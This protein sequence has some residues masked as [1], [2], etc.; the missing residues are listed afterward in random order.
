[1]P[2]GGTTL[3]VHDA[4]ANLVEI[5][6][7]N[8]RSRRLQYDESGRVVA[9][10]N[11]EGH[12]SRYSY[13]AAGALRGVLLSNGAQASFDVDPDGHVCR[14]VNP[15]GGV[16]EL[17]WA[18]YNVVHEIRRPAG[19]VV[20]FRYDR[21]CN[22][23]RIINENGEEHV[24]RR[25]AAGRIAGETHF[26][27]RAYR[28]QLDPAG[29]LARLENGAGEVTEIDRDAAGRVKKRTYEDGHDKFEYDADGRLI[30]GET[31]ATSCEFAY[32]VRGNLVRESQ[33]TAGR[34]FV[35][36]S[37][38]DA[39]GSRVAVRT[40]AGEVRFER[41][42]MCALR[43][44]HLPGGATIERT[45]DGLGR[46]ILRSLPGGGQIWQK[47]SPVGALVER[48][49]AGP[50]QAASPVSWVGALPAN[51]VFAESYVH[52]AGGELLEHAD[53]TGARTVFEH[54]PGGRVLARKASRGD[55]E[56]YAHD[57][58][59]R[60]RE[61]GLH[62]PART[63]GAGGALLARGDVEYTYDAEARRIARADRGTGRADRYVW[64]SRGLLAAVVLEGGTRVENVHDSSARRLLKRVV[65]PGGVV[66]E[67][68]FVWSGDHIIHEITEEVRGPTRSVTRERSYVWDEDAGQLL[69]EREVRGGVVGP[70]VHHAL[71][72]GDFPALLVGDDGQLAGRMRATLWGAVESAEGAAAASPWRYSGQYCDTETGL[73]Y[74]RYRF[75]DPEVGHY[76]NADPVGV[77]GGLNAFE[78]AK[79]QPL[80]VVDPDGLAPPVK[81]T[82]GGHG[83]KGKGSS[84]GARKGDPELHPIVQQALPPPVTNSKGKEIYPRGDDQP[85]SNCAEPGALSDYIR[86]WEAKNN[87]GKPLDP[88]NPKDR[89]KI[90]KCLGDITEIEAKHT[91]GTARAPCPN[92][93][94]MLSNLRDKWGAP[95]EKV[96]VPGPTSHK[97]TDSAKSSPASKEWLK[98]K[99][100][101]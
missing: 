56:R 65:S 31:E 95:K 78:Y 46:E 27:R 23:V 50:T 90:Q 44:V 12:V 97:G 61:I 67:T 66:T 18:G 37:T 49:I 26:D 76:I 6:E 81:A 86:K 9:V 2:N 64:D 22:L 16:F 41:D 40:P 14:Y 1:M 73:F 10:S 70:W 75:Y 15:D 21:E 69:A 71:G 53:S 20:R 68:R 39:M 25:D 77:S 85:P 83:V 8:G 87:G 47:W 60:L 72:A 33:S 51:A 45:L 4:E 101:K 34:T 92:C 100:K 38:F 24:I 11:E 57:G 3:F 54:D 98:G 58:G 55:I 80:Q 88:N 30:R 28:Y 63:Y 59:G 48:F 74:N 32:D 35:I 36:E 7:P 99:K 13:D 43:R 91:D 79:G 93:S 42:A 52:S 84:A 29:R 62:A 94:Q 96:V 5:V 19:D 17:L 89:G 82:V